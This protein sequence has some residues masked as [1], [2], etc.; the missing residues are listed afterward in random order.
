MISYLVIMDDKLITSNAFVFFVAG[1]DTAASTLSYCMFELSRNPDI[2]EEAY[3][4]ILEVLDK[5]DGQ[6]TY[7]AIKDMTL[8]SHIFAGKLLII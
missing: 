7:E 2:Q 8:I 6:L 3:Q 5:H 1:F 4:H